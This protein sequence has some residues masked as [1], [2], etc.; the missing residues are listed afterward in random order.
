MHRTSWILMT[1]SSQKDISK[2][3][4]LLGCRHSCSI[5]ITWLDL[6]KCT[7]TGSCDWYPHPGA[8]FLAV[9]MNWTTTTLP[10]IQLAPQWSI[11]LT[12]RG[13]MWRPLP[14]CQRHRRS[15]AWYVVKE[16]PGAGWHWVH[17][18]HLT[19]FLLFRSTS[20]AV[21]WS[22]TKGPL[23]PLCA[24]WLALYHWGE[25]EVIIQSLLF[26]FKASLN[27]LELSNF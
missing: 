15:L 10:S 1:R 13:L 5:G 24:L 18:F 8:C 11:L 14:S 20:T 22:A 9:N 16:S 27:F 6:S 2:A 12:T 21:P 4:V 19:L 23:T 3:E 25:N 26:L 7:C 17:W